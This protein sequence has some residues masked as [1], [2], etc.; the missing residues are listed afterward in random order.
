MTTMATLG[1]WFLIVALWVGTI[2]LVTVQA[3]IFYILAT[4]IRDNWQKHTRTRHLDDEYRNLLDQH[5]P[6]P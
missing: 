6:R 2:S 3:L 4:E 5:D 1:H